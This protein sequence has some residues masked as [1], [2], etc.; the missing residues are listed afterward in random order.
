MAF[1]IKAQETELQRLLNT[2]HSTN[3]AP[4]KVAET[5]SH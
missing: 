1:E 4:Q 2:L 5:T 3:A